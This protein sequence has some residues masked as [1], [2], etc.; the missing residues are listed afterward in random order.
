MTSSN[1]EDEIRPHLEAATPGPWET[2]DVWLSAGLIYSDGGERVEDGSATRCAFC[3]LGEPSWSGRRDIN[4]TVMPAH[5]HRNPEPYGLDHAISSADGSL[6]AYEGGGV[7][8]GEDV[9]FAV[10]ARNLLPALLAD[11]SSLRAEVAAARKF[12]AEMRDFCS[13][14]A[15]A[16][17]YADRLVEAMDRAKEAC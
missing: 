17:D 13:P 6:V 4:G 8:R 3:H 12:A 11:V 10:S 2:G 1:P 9:Q 7:V 5:R 15:I 16:A 14:H